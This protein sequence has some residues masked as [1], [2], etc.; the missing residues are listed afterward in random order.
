MTKQTKV[1]L[2]IAALLIIAGIVFVLLAMNAGHWDFS[3][4]NTAAYVTN[5]HKIQ[6]AFENISIDT[7]TTDITLLASEDDSC[8]VVCLEDAKAVH[9]V[10]VQ[11]GTLAIRWTDERT[12]Y[13]KI[14]ILAE[15]QKVTIYLP[16]TAYD[17]LM[18]Q[19]HTGDIDIPKELRFENIDITATTGDVK[20]YASASKALRIETNTGDIHVN[21][22]TADSMELCVS[23]G[24]VT[25]EGIR[26]TGDILLTVSTGDAQFT[27]LTCKALLS[28]GNTGDLSLQNVIAKA[29]FSIER[30]TGDVRFDGC[31]ATEIF[32]TTDTGDVTG[33]LLSDKVFLIDTDTGRVDVPRTT[34]GGRC[35][36]TTDTGDI[37]MQTGMLQ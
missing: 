5:T 27:D 2:M 14:G 4:L 22:V 7:D 21:G 8:K 20:N 15:T 26:C 24:K 23:T 19:E 34:T 36:V 18:I 9:T 17:T 32:V 10:S 6:E 28:T 29:R 1:W 3:V 16:D 33:T 25:A 35:K 31:D 30:S 13:E 12:W 37:R 11:D